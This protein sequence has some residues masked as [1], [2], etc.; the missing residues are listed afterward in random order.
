M[1]WLRRLFSRKEMETDLDRELR[2]HFESQVADKVRSG[3]AK[4]EAR[5]LT[6]WSSVARSRSRKTAGKLVAP[7]SLGTAIG[8]LVLPSIPRLLAGK[9]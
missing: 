8:R 5:R 1:S 3:M 6:R 2:F 4:S 9:S 7:R